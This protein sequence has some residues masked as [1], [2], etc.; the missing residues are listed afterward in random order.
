MGTNSYFNKRTRKWAPTS[1]R[2][3]QYNSEIVAAHTDYQI[4]QKNKKE[5]EKGSK[6]QFLELYEKIG[7]EAAKEQINS[8]FDREVFTDEILK[9]WIEERKK[10]SKNRNDDEDAR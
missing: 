7:Y 3:R 9:K 6:L 4:R 5:P 2:Q 10:E 8:R 1:Y